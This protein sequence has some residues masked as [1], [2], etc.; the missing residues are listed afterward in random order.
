M[1]ITLR[2]DT[3][4]LAAQLRQTGAEVQAQARRAA[5]NALRDEAAGLR[6]EVRRHVGNRMTVARKSFLKA[7][8]AKVLAQDPS[9]YPALYVGSKIPWSGIHESGGTISGKLLIPLHGRVGRKT[10]KAQVDALIRSGNAYFVR[11][12]KGHVVLMAENLAE[13]DKPL[14]G[15]KRRYRKNAGIKRL[16]RGADIPI[17]VLVPKVTLRK[18]LDLESVVKGRLP[19]LSEAVRQSILSI[20]T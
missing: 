3:R 12:A 4:A 18:R 11:N 14:A 2:T 19:K 7:F 16:K 15:F 1:R 6:E 17:A 5:Q 13:N 20:E 9:R 10:F 8:T